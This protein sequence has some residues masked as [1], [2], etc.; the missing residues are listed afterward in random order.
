MRPTHDIQVLLHH[1]LGLRAQED[2]H[3]QDPAC[4]PPAEGWAGL[5]DHIWRKQPWGS[6]TN[7]HPPSLGP[8]AL[9]QWAKHLLQRSSRRELG[10]QDSHS[11]PRSLRDLEQ[12]RKVLSSLRPRFLALVPLLTSEVSP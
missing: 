2:V 9:H 6:G 7:T 11:K 4:R 1:A 3:V 12:D 8:S 10:D 5:Q